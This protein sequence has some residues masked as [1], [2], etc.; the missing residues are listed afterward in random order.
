MPD[1]LEQR[2]CRVQILADKLYEGLIA[3]DGGAYLAK[4][5]SLLRSN[6]LKA[7]ETKKAFGIIL[8]ASKQEELPPNDNGDRRFWSK[9]IVHDALRM[10]MKNHGLQLPQLPGFQWS[11]WFK[12]QTALVHDLAKRANRNQRYY[13]PMAS[14]DDMDTLPYNVEDCVQLVFYL[15]SGCNK[16]KI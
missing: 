13:K 16:F 5:G 14:S 2:K 7:K 11:E 1:F 3:G 4:T 6:T 10:M 8:E 9:R 12:S 15:A